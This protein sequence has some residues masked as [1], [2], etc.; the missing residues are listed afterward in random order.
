M[1][2][3]IYNI[4]MYIF[5]YIYIY[6]RVQPVLWTRQQPY[7]DLTQDVSVPT[8]PDVQSVQH[9]PSRTC[10]PDGLKSGAVWT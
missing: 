3:Y 8:Y 7:V 6:I 2:I 4:Y 9:Q 10:G 5:I 1:Y